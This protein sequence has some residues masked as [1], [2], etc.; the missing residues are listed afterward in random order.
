[1]RTQE[2]FSNAIKK[3]VVEGLVSRMMRE[4][5]EEGEEEWRVLR[6]DGDPTREET[7]SS[8]LDI[9]LD[10]YENLR[11]TS[12]YV[13]RSMLRY[14]MLPSIEQRVD[15]LGKP[16]Q[17]SVLWMT[18][19]H[20]Y[21]H[22]LNHNLGVYGPECVIH[23]GSLVGM[24]MIGVYSEYVDSVADLVWACFVM[25][26]DLEKY[27][28]YQ[29]DGTRITE[30]PEDLSQVIPPESL[31]S[32]DDEDQPTVTDIGGNRRR[33]VASTGAKPANMAPDNH[34]RQPDPPKSQ[35]SSSSSSSK[36]KTTKRE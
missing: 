21:V 30:R 27:P 35:G 29:E 20:L 15:A 31:E 32:E 25:Q 34:V 36:E 18:V 17:R 28:L 33:H 22:I 5:E 12:P 14:D 24:S 4:D 26:L 2:I 13:R 1:M 10:I 19:T 8:S 7:A 11:K 6:D 3:D 9:L 23:K 16:Y